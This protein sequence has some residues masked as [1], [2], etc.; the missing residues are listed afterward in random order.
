M[1]CSNSRIS[2][3]NWRFMTYNLWVWFSF[4][5]LLC[6]RSSVCRNIETLSRK[7]VT[8]STVFRWIFIITSGCSSAT[9]QTKSCKIFT[10]CSQNTTF[11]CTLFNTYVLK[12][13]SKVEISF[14]L[15][16]LSQLLGNLSKL[17]ITW[18]IVRLSTYWDCIL[19][20]W[21]LLFALL[22]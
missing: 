4:I 16:I 7:I 6:P 19:R 11:Y 18:I 17:A 3:Q 14:S 15:T 5:L 1:S 21:T 20:F 9:Q 10:S 2:I 22:S 8:S 12:F 13:W